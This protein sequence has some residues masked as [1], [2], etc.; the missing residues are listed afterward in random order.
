MV[1]KNGIIN[2]RALYIDNI[3]RSQNPM[4]HKIAFDSLRRFFL[5]AVLA[6]LLITLSLGLSAA[7]WNLDTENLTRISMLAQGDAITDPSSLLRYALPIDNEKVRQLQKDIEELS[8]YLRSKRWSPVLSN[9]KDANVILTLKSDQI[10]K[11]VP[12]P[13]QAEAQAIIQSLTANVNELKQLTEAKDKENIW[14][15]RREMLEK[16]SQLE[17]LMV[18]GF[19]FEVPA[20]YAYLPQL[21][22]RATVEMETTKGVITVVLDGYS[23]PVNAGNFADLVKRGF[24]DGLPFTRAEDYFVLQ[25]GDPPGPAEGYI[26]EKTGVYRAIPMEVLVKGE[27]LPIYG[28]TLEEAGIYLADPVL[29]FSAYGALALARPADD[30]NGGSSQFFFFKFDTE[31]TPPGFNLMDGRYSVFGYV[32]KGKEVLDEITAE[33]KIIAAKIVKGAENLEAPQT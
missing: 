28:T 18:V 29:P 13:R 12:E 5:Q 9:V 17:E 10:L 21:K 23:A 30:A 11:S 26:D 8:K 3:P 4:K 16:I 22:G 1:L 25:A 15:K 33:D 20:E 27:K 24:Y 31:V 32:V 2:N 19:P 7:T 6:V 14:G